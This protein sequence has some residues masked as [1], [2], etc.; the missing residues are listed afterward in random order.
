MRRDFQY[1]YIEKVCIIINDDAAGCSP[2]RAQA[3]PMAGNTMTRVELVA[4]KLLLLFLLFFLFLV[5]VV[6][7]CW[8][9]CCVVLFKNKFERSSDAY[10]VR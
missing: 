9:C 7:R 2:R 1:M 4:A 5:C 10:A 8:L 3:V 6:C